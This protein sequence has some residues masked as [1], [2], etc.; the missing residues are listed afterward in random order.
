[1]P[2][3]K[4]PLATKFVDDKKRLVQEYGCHECGAGKVPEGFLKY[5]DDPVPYKTRSFSFVY[6]D[7]QPG[8]LPISKLVRRRGTTPDE[9]QEALARSN[10]IC[11]VCAFRKIGKASRVQGKPQLPR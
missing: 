9:L 5:W 3:K 10:I 4:T 2:N 1:M 11:R 6:H 8:D 7:P